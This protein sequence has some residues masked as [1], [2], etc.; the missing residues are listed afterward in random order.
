[1]KIAMFADSFRPTVDGAV[2]SMEM[3]AGALERRGHKVVM[4]APDPGSRPQV[5]WPVHYLPSREFKQYPGYRYVISPSD[6][7]EFLRKEEVDVIHSHGLASMAILS[8]T[9]SRALKIPHVLT[10]H[11]MAN[12]AAKYYSPFKIREDIIQELVWVYLRNMLRRPEVV[13]VPSAPIR[14]ELEAN[15][16]SMKICDVVPTGVDC[17]RFT[18]E[19]YDRNFLAK[20]GLSGKQVLLHVG[21]LSLE[22]RLDIVL[23]AM[24]ELARELPDLRLLVAGNGPAYEHYEKMAVELGISDRVVFAGF[25]SDEDLPVAYASSEALVIAS[26]F[27]TQG[28]VVLEALA[29]GTP[30]AGIRFRAIPE[31]VQEGKNGCLFDIGTCP[32]AIRRC[33]S[34]ADS[35]K[36][37]AVS[38]ARQY[39]VDACTEK[40]EAAYGKAI[41]V[42]E[43]HG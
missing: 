41:E 28:M 17:K 7:L 1:M 20:Y 21:R 16:V 34:R 33:L 29:S 2:I 18:P 6:M 26:T 13:V 25:L 15:G 5:K 22:K 39:S 43:K 42:L 35:M 31:F 30:V 9:A 14:E 36:I 3:S 10:F 40:L 32:E 12:E 38:S 27:E 8:L 23:D 11:T 4:L 37:N 19:R 24:K